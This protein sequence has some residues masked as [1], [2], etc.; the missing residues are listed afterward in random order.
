MFWMIRLISFSLDGGQPELTLR[1]DGDTALSGLELSVECF[2]IFGEALPCGA[3]GKT[4]QTVICAAALLPGE[5]KALSALTWE[6]P[7]DRLKGL[8][9]M[10][11]TVKKACLADGRV[12]RLAPDAAGPPLEVQMP[13]YIGFIPS[14]QEG[15]LPQKDQ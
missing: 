13:G 3:D 8:G 14:F 7:P 12:V 5:A 9:R 4:L 2:N 1:S 15:T 10:V 6:T 11:L